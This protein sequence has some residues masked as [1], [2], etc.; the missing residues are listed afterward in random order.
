MCLEWWKLDSVDIWKFGEQ[1]RTR[2]VPDRISIFIFVQ[3]CIAMQR[4]DLLPHRGSSAEPIWRGRLR[5]FASVAPFL[6]HDLRR[7]ASIMPHS[8]ANKMGQPL[9]KFKC[10][11]K[12]VP[13]KLWCPPNPHLWIFRHHHAIFVVS[14][15]SAIQLHTLCRIPRG[16]P[17]FPANEIMKIPNGNMEV[18]V[19][20]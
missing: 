9:A 14:R 19:S 6:T 13:V 16:V 17:F 11:A 5:Y 4:A 1:R 20:S 7:E 8:E 2:D 12:S 3:L 10:G 18:S 15:P